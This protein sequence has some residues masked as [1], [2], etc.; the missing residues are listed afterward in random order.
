MANDFIDEAYTHMGV[1]T[2]IMNAYLV[3]AEDG[4]LSVGLM[5]YVLNESD[6]PSLTHRAVMTKPLRTG[7]IRP[8]KWFTGHKPQTKFAFKS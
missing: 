3:K 6:V 4:S 1:L 7:K 8:S 5:L 2:L